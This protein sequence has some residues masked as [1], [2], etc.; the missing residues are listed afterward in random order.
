MVFISGDT[1]GMGAS[2]FL[3]QTGRPLLEK[4]FVPAELLR[5]VEQLLNT[6]APAKP[7]SPTVG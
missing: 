6:S 2:E 5:L 7:G 1:L 3:A 4:P